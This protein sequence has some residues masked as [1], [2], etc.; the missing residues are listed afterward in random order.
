M[1]SMLTHFRVDK[2]LR[3][4]LFLFLQLR[5]ASGGLDMIDR[6]PPLLD[7]VSAH[8][9]KQVLAQALRGGCTVREAKGEARGY[10][11]AISPALP[12][13]QVAEATMSSWPSWIP[14]W[15]T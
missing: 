4:V 1:T 13:T 11:K 7:P 9:V 15:A 3:I 12:Q 8:C 10:L 14:C 6:P 2:A 5:H